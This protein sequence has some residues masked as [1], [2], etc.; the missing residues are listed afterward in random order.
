MLRNSEYMTS[1]LPVHYLRD[2]IYQEFSVSSISLWIFFTNQVPS[3]TFIHAHVP[4]SQALIRRVGS[5]HY[6]K[7]LLQLN[8]TITP[9]KIFEMS[10]IKRT[11]KIVSAARDGAERGAALAALFTARTLCRQSRHGLK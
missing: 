7:F 8:L 3:Q 11:F 6:L 9:D 2:C 10:V 4:S 1:M 5:N